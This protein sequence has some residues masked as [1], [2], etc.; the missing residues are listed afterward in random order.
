MR[1]A[2]DGG[3]DGPYNESAPL[4]DVVATAQPALRQECATEGCDNPAS[5]HFVRGGIGSYYCHDCY[6]HVQSLAASTGEA[7]HG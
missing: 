2:L 5:V 7:N 6:M 4:A 1:E 3:I